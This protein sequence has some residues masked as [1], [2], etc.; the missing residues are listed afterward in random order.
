MGHIFDFVTDCLGQGDVVFVMDRSRYVSR[1]DL[2]KIK[3]F[4]RHVVNRLSFKNGNHRVAV[5]D[6]GASSRVLVSLRDGTSKRAVKVP[7]ASVR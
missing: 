3:N 1:V 4:V 2:R 6:F 7:V 5:V